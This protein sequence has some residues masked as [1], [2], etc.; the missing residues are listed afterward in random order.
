MTQTTPPRRLPKALATGLG[1]ALI[2]GVVIAQT[3]PPP[4]IAW[5]ERRLERLDR[6]VRKLER[7]LT[8][9]N[10]A[11][12]PILIEADPEVVAMSS[13][14]D[15][16]D[17]RLSDLE[18]A[19][20]QANG[21]RESLLE[22][23][24]AATRANRDLGQQLRQLEGRFETAQAEA[25]RAAQTAAPADGAAAGP[26]P[27]SPSGSEAGDFDAAM[28]LVRDGDYDD[29]GEA[30]ELFIA[31][32]TESARLGEANYRLAETRFIAEDDQGAAQAY[33]ASL[34][35][36]PTTP[37]AADAVTKLAET[38]LSSD[39]APQACQALGEF[40]RRYAEGATPA[41][42]NRAQQLRTRAEC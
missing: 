40:D 5:D 14:V 38:L 7:A 27:R 15:Q 39:R 3:P 1:V 16:M 17:R 29:A 8:Q 34:R 9:R 36:W 33:A 28:R 23:L 37:W 20:L 18:A 41:L 35:G 22:N 12:D 6:N 25:E 10:A 24:E 19:L 26:R 11:G 21:D 32:W 13:R 30:F 42:R 2:G 4:P 31:T